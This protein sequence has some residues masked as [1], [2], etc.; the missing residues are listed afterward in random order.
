MW[1]FFLFDACCLTAAAKK[2]LLLTFLQICIVVLF[3]YHKRSGFLLL[4][5]GVRK[6]DVDPCRVLLFFLF[7]GIGFVVV[8]AAD[9]HSS[10]YYCFLVIHIFHCQSNR[11]YCLNALVCSN[12]WK[13]TSCP[14]WFIF[15]AELLLLLI[16]CCCSPEGLVF[17]PFTGI[18][19]SKSSSSGDNSVGELSGQCL[20]TRSRN[21]TPSCAAR[22]ENIPIPKSVS[23][24]LLLIKD[25]R[26]HSQEFGRHWSEDVAL[27][28]NRST[29]W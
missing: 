12:C 16:S 23:T 24:V 21:S 22:L 6:T 1:H 9:S 15:I 13:H 14:C 17:F 11:Y 25:R 7:F 18:V 26:C 20:R 29:G 8:C 27:D 19:D 28:G 3:C 10:G 2:V 5:D 4:S